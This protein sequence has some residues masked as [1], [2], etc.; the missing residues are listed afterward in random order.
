[1]K[2]PILLTCYS[3]QGSD[4]NNNSKLLIA[5]DC[6]VDQNFIDALGQKLKTNIDL[7][8]IDTSKKAGKKAME[9]H[10]SYFILA[11]KAISIRGKYDTIIFW[12]QFVGLYWGVLSRFAKKGKA[13]V[14]LLHLIYKERKGVLG[15]IHKLFFSFSLSNRT[16]VGATCHSS[17]ELKY[18]QKIFYSCKDKVFFIP[19]GQSYEAINK[20]IAIPVKKPYFFSGGT[21]NRD[22]FTLM[23]VAT[24]MNYNFVVACTPKDVSGI[25]ISDNVTVFFDAYGETFSSLMDSSCAV[26]FTLKNPNISSGQLVLLKAMA[27]E[28]P[29]V[30]TKSSG[31]LDYVDDTCAFLVEHKNVEEI[32]RVLAFIIANPKEAQLKAAEAK[33]RYQEAFSTQKFAFSLAELVTRKK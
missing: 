27:M 1:M 19:Y 22:Y 28:K 31:I 6:R 21:S 8:Y 14:F 7:L 2:K 25:A 16:L 9:R 24:M 20:N 15:K 10:L 18:Y 23:S 3:C 13:K 5:A 32:Q 12:Q 33:K 17:Q 26:L 30:A 11:Q 4:N 29:I